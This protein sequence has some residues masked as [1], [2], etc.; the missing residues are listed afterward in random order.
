MFINYSNT[1]LTE[2][3]DDMLIQITN[4]ALY[5]LICYKPVA[6]FLNKELAMYIYKHTHGNV[7]QF[8]YATISS[9]IETSTYTDDIVQE[10]INYVEK[11][12]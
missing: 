5:E 4:K 10:L 9:Y 8:P 1:C 6:D 2:H 12:E 7:A 3:I 11:A